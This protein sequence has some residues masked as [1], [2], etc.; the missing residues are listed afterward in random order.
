MNSPYN[1]EF[2]ITQQ[3]KGITHK[4]FDIVGI[5]DK[6]IHST[7]NGVVEFAG[8]DTHPTG[9]MGHYIRIKES[10]TKRCYYF[11][12]LSKVHVAIGQKVKQGDLIGIEGNTG[13]S[14]GSHLH[15]E[16]RLTT[17][18]TTFL[19]ISQIS[20]IP[21]KL[22][23]YQQEEEEVARKKIDITIGNTKIKGELRDDGVTMAPL[24]ELIDAIKNELDVTWSSNSGAG[25]DL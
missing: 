16:A 14:T 23:K 9:G 18:N 15:Y 1:G 7:V 10:G 13:H 25:I 11:T 21:N 4:G 19:D 6:N 17:N 24:R 5:T 12:H 2:K 20:G 8:W 3:Y 22:G